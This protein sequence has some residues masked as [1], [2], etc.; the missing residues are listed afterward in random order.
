MPET[1]DHSNLTREVLAFRC[2]RW[3]EL[4]AIELYMDQLTG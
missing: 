4:P 2:P 3:D 1:F